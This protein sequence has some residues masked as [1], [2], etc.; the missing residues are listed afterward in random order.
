MFDI[1][2]VGNTAAIMVVT[3][4][5]IMV[6]GWKFLMTTRVELIVFVSA[7]CLLVGSALVSIW[8]FY[9]VYFETGLQIMSK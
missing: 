6:I 3:G 1:G 8:W 4:W 2:T 5:A 7:L 9:L